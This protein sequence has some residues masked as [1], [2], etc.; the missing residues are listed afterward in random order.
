MTRAFIGL[1]QRAIQAYKGLMNA[2]PP[3]PPGELSVMQT[4]IDALQK[5]IDTLNQFLQT[6]KKANGG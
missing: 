5:K 1:Y 6:L 4:Q 3:P 2:I